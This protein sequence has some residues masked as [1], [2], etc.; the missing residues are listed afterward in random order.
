MTITVLLTQSV[1]PEIEIQTPLGSVDLHNF[2]HFERLEYDVEGTLRLVWISPEPG[3]FRL[4][5]RAIQRAVLRCGG[6]KALTVTPR[7]PE[8]PRSEDSTLE[9]FEILEVEPGCCSMRFTFQ[10]GIKIQ[11]VAMQ[12]ELE[13]DYED[14]H[15]IKHNPDLK[16]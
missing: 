2:A 7:D 5:T 3:K 8:I 6:V 16:H 15:E 14:A 4:G 10:G 12:V 13:I 11:V 9:D 1:Y